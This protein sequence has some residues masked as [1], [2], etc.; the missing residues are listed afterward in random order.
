MS[1]LTCFISIDERLSQLNRLLNQQSTNLN[2][3]NPEHVWSIEYVNDFVL[4]KYH[5]DKVFSENMRNYMHQ[6]Y[7]VKWDETLLGW[8][9]DKKLFD[10]KVFEEIKFTF[11]EWK[12]FDKR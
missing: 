6:M 7:K 1:E 2:C 4:V 10:T 3:R 9:V 12:C 8:Q 11:P 5:Y